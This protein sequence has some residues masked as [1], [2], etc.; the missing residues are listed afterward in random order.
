MATKVLRRLRELLD[1]DTSAAVPGDRLA[2]D[3]DG[4][5][6]VPFTPTGGGAAGAPVDAAYLVTTSDPDLT[7]EVV[8]GATPGGE[9]GGTWASPTVDTTHAGS[10]HAAVQAAAE[11]TAAAALAAHEGASDPHPV[12]VTGS[13]ATTAILAALN[14][15]DGAGLADDGSGV[16]SVNVDG[17]TLE[18]SA[19][20]LRV[21]DG[22]ITIAK[23]SFD[24]ATQAELDAHVNDTSAAHAA[25]AI[26]F[27]PTGSIASTD[28]QAAIAE[29]ASEAGG[30]PS[31]SAGGALDGSYPNPGLAASVAGA[32]LAETSDVLSVNVDGSTLEINSDAL[33]VKAAGILAS[34][35]GDAELA[36][37]AGLTSAADKV[38]YFTGSGSAALADLSSF[39]RTLLDD[40]TA[41]AARA[42]LGVNAANVFRDVYGAPATAFDFDTSSLTGLTQFNSPDTCDANTTVPGHL[43]LE[44]DESGENMCGVYASAPAAPFTVAALLDVGSVLADSHT[45]G[46]LIGSSTPGQF[47][48]LALQNAARSVFST[49]W[50]S[51]TSFSSTF[52]SG[53][54]Q[55]NIPIWLAIRVNSNTDVDFLYSMDGVAFKKYTDSR[56][57][58]FTAAVVG[59]AINANASG[60][61]FAAAFDWLYIYTSALTFKGANA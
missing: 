55:I 27:T 19:D 21:K 6:W 50:N 18:I 8:V 47:D 28:V 23:L 12:Y 16:L 39:M 26:G 35:I 7:S 25:S 44:D 45:A 57:P 52:T 48:I 38:P 3:V 42:T 54:S 59:L 20:A 33:R 5:T 10:S 61:R 43:F 40:T 51:P 2:L 14:L 49:H 34:H 9:L 13:E 31:G 36:A 32:G 15:A 41:A 24:P 4:E 56:N 1:V 46:L 17:S 60:V 29:V 58:G 37:L 11:A 22:G 30:A 53:M